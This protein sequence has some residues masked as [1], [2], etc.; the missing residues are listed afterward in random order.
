M[1]HNFHVTITKLKP[2]FK[3]RKEFKEHNWK[4]GEYLYQVAYNQYKHISIP[5][6]VVRVK[7]RLVDGTG[8]VYTDGKKYPPYGICYRYPYIKDFFFNRKDAVKA[9]ETAQKQFEP[10]RGNVRDMLWN[11]WYQTRADYICNSAK[12]N[13]LFRM[14]IMN[15]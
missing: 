3:S 6:K 15:P 13:G 12:I 7:V 9:L 10:Q 4:E 1:S 8:W 14:K 5:Y 11:E 2:V